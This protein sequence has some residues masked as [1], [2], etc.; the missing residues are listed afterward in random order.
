MVKRASLLP[1]L[2]PPCEYKK[3]GLLGSHTH[4]FKQSIQAVA[5]VAAAV[6]VTL[7]II[8]T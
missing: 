7:M 5:C 3:A 1:E 4:K 2:A 8:A 6:V